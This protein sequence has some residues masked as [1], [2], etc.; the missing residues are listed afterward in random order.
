MTPLSLSVKR[1]LLENIQKQY[2]NASWQEKN[3]LIDGLTL[4]TG[5]SRKYAINLLNQSTIQKTQRIYQ[6]PP[7]YDEVFKQALMTLWYAANQICSK[8]FVPFIAELLD[9]LEKHGHVHLPEDDPT[10]EPNKYF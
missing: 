4:T 9:S 10:I 3:K 2:Q 5:Y 8:R 1:K 7:K 6:S